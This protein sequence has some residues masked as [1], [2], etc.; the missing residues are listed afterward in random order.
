MEARRTQLLSNSSR[1]SSILHRY[2]VKPEYMLRGNGN[3]SSLLGEVPSLGA[4][5]TAGSLRTDLLH[6][7]APTDLETPLQIM[8]RTIRLRTN[9][10][11]VINLARQFFESHQNG[12]ISAPSFTWRIVCE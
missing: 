1:Y 3:G 12:A 10:R 7:F 6:R 8:N 2:P 9:S 5:V 11:G 4:D